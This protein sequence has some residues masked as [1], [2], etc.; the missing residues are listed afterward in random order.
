MKRIIQNEHFSSITVDYDF[1]LLELTEPIH[2]DESKQAIQLHN[3]DEVF[4][5]DTKCLISGWG[6]TQNYTESNLE[7]RA[8]FYQCKNGFNVNIFNFRVIFQP[9]FLLLIKISV[10]LHING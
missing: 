6:T 4:A 2:F 10:A 8:G 1:A 9:L 7:L 5:D 3:F